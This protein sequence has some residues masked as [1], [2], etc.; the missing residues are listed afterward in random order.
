LIAV[1]DFGGWQARLFGKH[2]LHLD[3]P[4]HL[5]HFTSF[6][7]QKA[8]GATG[9]QNLLSWHQELEYDCFGWIQSALNVAGPSANV[10]FDSLTGKPPRTG[11]I[12]IAAHYA[13]AAAMA[14]PALLLTAAG[15]I[16]RRGG[17]LVVA[18]SPV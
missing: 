5:F 16:A 13:A 18:A 14:V 6:S 12:L 11:R 17:T 7:L 1:P 9:Y 3:V 8:L 2:W 4:R 10:L 15:S